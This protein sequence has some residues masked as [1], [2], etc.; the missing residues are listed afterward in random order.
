MNPHGA[1]FLAVYPLDL[2]FLGSAHSSGMWLGSLCLHFQSIYDAQILCFHSWC[3]CLLWIHQLLSSVWACGCFSFFSHLC[4][5]DLF[6]PT[7]LS[8]A[9]PKRAEILAQGQSIFVVKGTIRCV[10]RWIS[11][12]TWAQ[13]RL[14]I[15]H[16][17]IKTLQTSTA[18]TLHPRFFSRVKYWFLS[19]VTG[20]RC[21]FHKINWLHGALSTTILVH[22]VSL[23]LSLIKRCFS[24]L[25]QD[26]C[27]EA[28]WS[29]S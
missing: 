18:I 23:A 19:C 17:V 26:K 28:R 10:L 22:E 14:N 15:S 27:W 20:R 25:T 24:Q 1:A 5:F 3:C 2:S 4:A 8:L 11:L 12:Y 6:K 21:R 9:D 7:G 29:C 13:W 16:S